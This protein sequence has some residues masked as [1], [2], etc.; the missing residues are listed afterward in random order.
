MSTHLNPQQTL[1][2]T[3]PS[4]HQARPRLCRASKVSGSGRPGD[5]HERNDDEHS[6]DDCRQQVPGSQ[7]PDQD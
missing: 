4:K 7:Q 5:H 1:D 3:R 2:G 6:D